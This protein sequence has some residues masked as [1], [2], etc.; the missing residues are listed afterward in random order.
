M[1]IAIVTGSLGL[2]GAESVR[3]LTASGLKVVGIDNINTGLDQ[4]ILIIGNLN[5]VFFPG[6]NEPVYVV[7]Q[8]KDG[9]T[10]IR[11]ITFNAFKYSAAVMQNMGHDMNFCIL[12][13]DD[14]TIKP[15]IF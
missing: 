6:L 3:F 14:F 4:Y 5:S 15:D 9:W 12:P 13:R 7:A 10:L 8:T 11:S 2:I 1:D